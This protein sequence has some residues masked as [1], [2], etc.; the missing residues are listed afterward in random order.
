MSVGGRFR[1]LRLRAGLTQEQVVSLVQRRGVEVSQSYIAHLEAERI[2]LPNAALLHSLAAAV[3]CSTADLLVAGGYL[4]V[5]ELPAD[6]LALGYR[7]AEMPPR[8]RA[9]I[10][11][12]ALMT[13]MW[14]QDGRLD[15][16]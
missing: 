2:N 9:F 4:G 5:A 8:I 1:E 7:L 3:G 14:Y 13:A 16:V 12:Q 6:V 11:D 10:V 15:E